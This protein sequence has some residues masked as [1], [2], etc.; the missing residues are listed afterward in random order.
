[1]LKNELAEQV[2]AEI[3]DWRNNGWDDKLRK[4]QTKEQ[5]ALDVNQV[6]AKEKH[7]TATG[8]WLGRSSLR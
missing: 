6:N 5:L 2:V 4:L 8:R 1:M 3:I 7:N